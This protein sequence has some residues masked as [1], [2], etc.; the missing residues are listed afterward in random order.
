VIGCALIPFLFV[1]RRGL[2]ETP[3]FLARAERPALGDILTLVARHGAVVG[4]GAMMATLTTVAFYMITA[5]TP[6]YGAGVLHLTLTS[7]FVITVCV[8]ASNLALLPLAGAV[9][10]RIGRLPLLVGAAGIV[11]TTSYPALRW[12][13]SGPSFDRLL[14]VE[15]WLSAAY[16]AYNGAMVVY[17]TEVMPRAIRT[18]GFSLAYSLATALFGGFTPLVCT[19]LIHRTHDKAAPGLWLTAAALVGLI[20]VL[21]LS[22]RARGFSRSPLAQ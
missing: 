13:A 2:R 19:W 8:G 6:T 12:L 20:G 21:G 22:L 16:A 3:A 1:I 10:D 14:T 9:S 18:T 5:Y 7:A 11:L 15:L 4:L 17:L